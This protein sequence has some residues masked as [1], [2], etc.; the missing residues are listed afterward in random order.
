MVPPDRLT[1]PSPA[2]ST[3][4][5]HLFDPP[6]ANEVIAR[7]QRIEV[8][9]DEP[10]LDHDVVVEEEKVT[11]PRVLGSAIPRGR[12]PTVVL[13]DYAKWER[14]RQRA[15]HLLSRG[16]GTVDDDDQLEAPGQ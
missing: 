1:R 14:R 5:Q 13:D 4:G 16:I 3:R 11:A 12:L 15:Q 9:S 8:R 2:R 10:L 7:S 6:D